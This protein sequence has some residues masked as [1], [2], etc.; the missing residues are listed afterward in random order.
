[1]EAYKE[2]Y[3]HYLKRFYKAC[4]YFNEHEEDIPKF[5]PELNKIEDKLSEIINLYDIK[6]MKIIMHGFKE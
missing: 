3:N 2:E 4:N 1:M 5:L 6:D